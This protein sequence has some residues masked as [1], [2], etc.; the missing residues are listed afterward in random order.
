[1]RHR[2]FHKIRGTSEMKDNSKLQDSVTHEI[3]NSI[4][5]VNLPLLHIKKTI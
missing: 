4:G 2:N 5:R 1:M 3:Q